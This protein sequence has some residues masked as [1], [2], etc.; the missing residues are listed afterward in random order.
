MKNNLPDLEDTNYKLIQVHA[1]LKYISNNLADLSDAVENGDNDGVLV[2]ASF[3]DDRAFFTLAA[4]L[5]LIEEI[6]KDVEA[7]IIPI[8]EVSGRASN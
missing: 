6:Q 5:D 8:D 7:C 1:L 3:M 2:Q 4:A